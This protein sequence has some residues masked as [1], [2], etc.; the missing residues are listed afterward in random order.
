LGSNIAE[1]SPNRKWNTKKSSPEQAGSGESQP[2][3]P[4]NRLRE[5]AVDRVQGVP[6]GLQEKRVSFPLETDSVTSLTQRYKI[7][8][9]RALRE[10][11]R[12]RQK[13]REIK[14]RK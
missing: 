3:L 4:P 11:T 5:I 13:I 2:E 8:S 9:I 14:L 7:Q 1:N 6:I 10:S 12:K